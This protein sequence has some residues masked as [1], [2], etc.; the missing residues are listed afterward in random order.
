MNLSQ[1]RQLYVEGLFAGKLLKLSPK[2]RSEIERLKNDFWMSKSDRIREILKVHTE[3]MQELAEFT[4][5]AYLDAYREEGQMPDH[6][7]I[8]EITNKLSYWLNKEIGECVLHLPMDL[9]GYPETIV[10]NAVRIADK[11]LRNVIK[12]SELKSKREEERRMNERVI[13]EKEAKRYRVL[14]R[15]HE[16]SEGNS[17][18]EV[19]E[20]TIIE[21]EGVSAGELVNEILPYLEKEGLIRYARFRTVAI[22]HLG[23]REIEQAAKHPNRNTEHFQST[24]IQHFHGTVHNVQTGNQNTQNFVINMSPEFNE[25]VTK[26]LE[27]VHNSTLAGVV[28]DDAIEALERLPKLAQQEKAPD[29]LEAASKRLNLLKTTFEVVKLGAQAAPYLQYLYHWFQS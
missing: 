27:L 17:M 2:Y 29:V 16:E 25:A 15:I 9:L 24:I 20:D 4:I 3:N 19:S 18:V 11:D 8:V 12:D 5:N 6:N 7:H 23:I 28:K 14:R 26:L 22:D 21:K 13:A 10:K 1:D